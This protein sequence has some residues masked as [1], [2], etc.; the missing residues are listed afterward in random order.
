MSIWTLLKVWFFYFFP[1]WAWCPEIGEPEDA[2]CILVRAFGRNQIDDDE[3]GTKIL[4]IRSMSD[5]DNKRAFDRLRR[6]GFL[7]GAFNDEVA[8]QL[9]LYVLDTS[10]V[11]ILQWE[12]AF[13]MFNLSEE[14]YRDNEHRIVVLWPPK[15]GYFS[16]YEVK[17]AS[18]EEMRKR[19]LS[20]PLE[21]AHPAMIVRAVMIIWRLGANPIVSPSKQLWVWDGGSVQPWTR[22]FGLWLIREVLGRVHHIVF[23]LVAF[24]PPKG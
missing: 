11:L 3:L 1:F 17:K 19:G 22:G 4:R 18:V 7:S 8:L 10:H 2:D 5:G 24:R 13:S 16:T 20:C 23:R 21:V 12:V 9:F 14:W 6:G 15:S